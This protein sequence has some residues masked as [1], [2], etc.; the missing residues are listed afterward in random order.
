MGKY[1]KLIHS[2][3]CAVLAAYSLSLPVFAQTE[4]LQQDTEQSQST[5]SVKQSLP[6][7]DD[8]KDSFFSF[9][10]TPQRAISSGLKAFIK[11]TD[12]FFA[13]EK[14][15]Y[16]TSG[17]YLKWTGQA[18]Y[19]ES[20]VQG[21][22]SDLKLKTK[23]PL[24]EKKI[25]LLLESNPG[26]EEEEIEK[27]LE[28][29]PQQAVQEKN[30]FAGIQTTVGKKETWQFKP[31]LGVHLGHPVDYYLRFRLTR[32][33]PIAEGSFLFRQS[34]Y[35]FDSR[36]WESDTSGEI[37]YPVINNLL[38]RSTTGANWKEE[39]DETELRQIFSLTQKLS[40]RRAISYQVGFYGIN[41]PIRHTTYT[42]YYQLTAHYRQNLHSGYLFMDLIPQI[43]YHRE[44]DFRA[45]YSFTFR[46]EMVFK[47]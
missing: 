25:S 35:W 23:L 45:D 30:Y 46:L 29:T 2:F 44:Y 12:E 20:G 4:Q 14:V 10:D 8:D 18:V 37:N 31:S 42:S 22:Y 1:V 16:E 40:P 33:V 3:P 47:G 27:A 28:Q 34:A 24:T 13:D 41:E 26:E 5:D 17:S 43:T 36:G 38:F 9:L 11:S 39:T 32:E 19:N 21:Y 15:F 6:A 7:T